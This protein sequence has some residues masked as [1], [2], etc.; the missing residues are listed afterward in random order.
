MSRVKVCGLTRASDVRAAVDASADA[1]GTIVDVP[2]DTPRAVSA[3]DAR[4]LLDPVPPFVTAVL[5]TM[6]D[7]PRDV[8]RLVDTV[9]PDAV[10]LHAATPD[11]VTGVRERTGLP[12]V[13]GVD[14][15]APA[16]ARDC[17]A[18]ADAVLLDSVDEDGGG[19][20]GRT[21]DWSRT[22]EVAAT[23]DAP[24]VLAGGLTPANVAAAVRTV[25]PFAVDVASGVE[26]SGGVKD[27]AALEAFVRAAT[28]PRVEVEP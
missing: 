16:A 11:V 21:Q 3:D 8:A 10:Q 14:A 1:V 7:S 13:A 4:S 12:V 19:G 17:A 22:A 6:S 28:R 5:V 20:T 23:L 25:D 15:T 9:G 24:V 18:V 27:H 2:V 26:A